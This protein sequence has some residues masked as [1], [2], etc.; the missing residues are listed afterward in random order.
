[1]NL[2]PK[3]ISAIALVPKK[4]LSELSL[5]ERVSLLESIVANFLLDNYP[6]ATEQE[7][8]D[9]FNDKDQILD[10]SLVD[11][12]NKSIEDEVKQDPIYNVIAKHGKQQ[13]T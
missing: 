13:V 8:R 11:N 4:K 12:F 10:F 5:Q 2:E 3:D 9:L 6:G 7:V 1:M